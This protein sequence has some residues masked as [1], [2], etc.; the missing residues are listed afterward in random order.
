MDGCVL[1][2]NLKARVNISR[3]DQKTL[4]TTFQHSPECWNVVE[5]VDFSAQ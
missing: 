5:V 3:Q 4:T 1:A 2:Q